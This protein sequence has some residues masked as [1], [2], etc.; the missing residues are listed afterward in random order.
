MPGKII[1]RQTSPLLPETVLE[2]AGFCSD[3][4]F[5]KGK[6][7]TLRAVDRQRRFKWRDGEVIV[8][9]GK[10]AG[11]T[12]RDIAEHDP[13]FLRWIIRSDF[14]EDVKNIARNALIG[15]FPER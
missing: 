13:G 4:Y 7:P 8:N 14:P 5:S 11:R 6:L 15:K 10:N 9:F 1:F 2:V 3:E 12:L